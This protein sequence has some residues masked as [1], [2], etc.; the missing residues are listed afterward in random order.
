MKTDTHLVSCP[1][2]RCGLAIG[3]GLLTRILECP[4]CRAWFRV[5][6]RR[7]PPFVNN[8][9]A[10]S[11]WPETI[12]TLL[13][14]D[15]SSAWFPDLVQQAGGALVY[16]DS[17]LPNV[18]T[19]RPTGRPT[20]HNWSDART[21]SL[22]SEDRALVSTELVR[23][24]IPHWENLAGER[25]SGTASEVVPAQKAPHRAGMLLTLAVIGVLGLGMFGTI[26]WRLAASDLKHMHKGEMDDSGREVTET[27]YVL[28][29]VG[30]V[31][32]LVELSLLAVLFC[33]W[34]LS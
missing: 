13:S 31:R 33:L 22:P 11:F 27:A 2:C 1:G 3:E 15:E 10:S 8:W 21:L 5:H 4:R 14:R 23:W 18:T 30:L 34:R 12:G 32:A 7:S 28:G 6:L 20:L 29:L 17:E 24:P 16:P 26:A 9:S 25:G 19:S